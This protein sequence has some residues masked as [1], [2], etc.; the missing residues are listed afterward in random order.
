VDPEYM[1]MHK[2]RVGDAK[3]KTREAEQ[4]TDSREMR[5][6]LVNAVPINT[7]RR[8]RARL[9]RHHGW[10]Q[11][12]HCCSCGCRGLGGRW[13]HRVLAAPLMLQPG[14]WLARGTPAPLVPPGRRRPC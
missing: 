9:A 5:A 8:V 14:L 6:R 10:L 13:A 11:G 2:R 1:A 4:I 12:E 3:R 7:Q